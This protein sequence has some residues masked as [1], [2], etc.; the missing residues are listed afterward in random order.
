M[1]KWILLVGLLSGTFSLT[2]CSVL[3]NGIQRLELIW[4]INEINARGH[5]LLEEGDYTAGIA[6]LERAVALIYEAR[7]ELEHLQEEKRLGEVY[8]APFNNL[9]RARRDLGDY[10]RSLEYIEKALLIL[11][12]SDA[13]YVNKGNA[14]YGLDRNEEALDSYRQA[15]SLNED[16][17]YAYYGMGM[18]HYDQ[19]Q[20]EQALQAF[21]R[22]HELAPEDPDG[23]EWLGYVHL[24]MDRLD[25][26][27][28]Y[29]DMLLDMLEDDPAAAFP[30]KA[31]VLEAA[32]DADGLQQ[33]LARVA[34][35][36]PNSAEPWA[37]VIRRLGRLGEGEE[38]RAIFAEAT[39]RFPREGQLL[40]A[41]GDVLL[42]EG[43]PLS[44]LGYYEQALALPSG[45]LDA[46]NA[47]LRALY[48]GNRYLAC[49]EFGE[50]S[51]RKH[52]EEFGLLWLTGQCLMELEDYE[53]AAVFFESF[54]DRF[55]GDEDILAELA[56]ARLKLGHRSDAAA[57]AAA[58]L[59]L[60]P[61]QDLALYVNRQLDE[62]ER[63]LGERIA[64]FFREFYLY[65]TEHAEDL[66]VR[67]ETENPA[68]A[69][70]AAWIDGLKRADDPFTVFVYGEEYDALLAED[71]G[72][73]AHEMFGDLAYFRIYRFDRNTD[74]R[75]ILLADAIPEP[76]TKV[77]VLDLRGN[78]GGDTDSANRVLDALLPETAS[79]ML[80]DKYGYT[81]T[82]Y[83]D[84][85]WLPFR[86][87]YVLVDEWTASAAE[88]LALG[89][90]TYLDN[91]TLVGRPTYGK[92]VGQLVFEDPEHR[93][94][95]V[96]VNHYWNVRQRNVSDSPIRPDIA[97]EDDSLE[98][99]LKPAFASLRE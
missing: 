46:R 30:L 7:P 15:I 94:L 53:R 92:G 9:G 85:S 39:V 36:A 29:A 48:Y 79:S 18:I 62:L 10:E 27:G 38:A 25:E 26:A 75:F 13:E 61:H 55:P 58:S 81:S 82:Y 45:E 63:P 84:A 1:R 87:I 28:L 93:V 54:A 80:I 64:E 47:K 6:E 98:S 67:L 40:L 59:A 70:I 90:D 32:G 22:Y 42:D 43:D 99:Y 31:D 21:K 69:Q 23:V 49:V 5:A 76:E 17:L 97:V 24:A 50:Q 74:D 41:M 91:V 71:D 3:Q 66:L 2:A 34:S 86:E 83:S 12:N 56:Y 11:P 60:A 77:L 20:Y 33:L 72:F 73:L 16:S 57:A 44:A 88:L 35:R 65:E 96:V 68:P 19:W 37:G 78:T 51:L 14:L 89:L 52:P 8:D 4:E 95:F